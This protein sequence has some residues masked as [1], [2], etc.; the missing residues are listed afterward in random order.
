MRDDAER[1]AG[2]AGRVRQPVGLSPTEVAPTHSVDL[3]RASPVEIVS[4]MVEAD[5]RT[6]E[7]VRLATHQ[8][9][10]VATRAT[11]ALRSGGR[12]IFCGAGTSGRLGVIEAAEC[13]PTFQ[14]RPGQ[15][16]GLI[17]GGPEAFTTAI[18]G[19]EDSPER[20]R[21][22]VARAEVGPRDLVCG[23]AA[24]GRTPYVRGALT[25]A[26]RRSARTALITSN[27]EVA[28]EDPPPADTLVVLDTGPEVLCGSTRLRAGTAA[29]M[30]LNQITTAAFSGLGKVYG[31]LMVDLRA[32]NAKLRRRATRIVCAIA[33]CEP[34]EAEA[35]LAA[36]SGR[37]KDA[38][39]LRATPARSAAD[40]AARLARADGWLRR[41]LEQGADE[42]RETAP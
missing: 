31:A 40:A 35:A 15:V 37:V 34:A 19:A 13:M 38:V 7:A 10:K 4:L 22:D 16:V 25:E 18:E 6:V 5:T 39:V 28:E 21:E 32:T 23:I 27:P 26:R 1:H 36:T 17:A 11:E 33:G 12:L 3:D 9:A 30:A 42:R 29:K 41:A 20:G 8:V 24:S 2:G 14:S